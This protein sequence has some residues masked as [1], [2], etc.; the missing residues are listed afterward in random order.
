MD[1]FD[2]NRIMQSFRIIVDTRE[3]ET[4]RARQRYADMET[5]YSRAVLDYG[6]YTYNLTLPGGEL[7]DVSNRIKGRCV[8]ERKQ[9]LD[10][11]A[12]C[13]TRS[14]DRFKREFERA[15]AAGARVY[16]L[17]ENA[18]ID[19]ILSGQY[20]SRFRPQ[21][22]IASLMAWS[23]RNNMVT[24]FCDMKNS[25]RMIREILY[26]DAKERLERGEMWEEHAG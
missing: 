16:L 15:A 13:F 7:H 11:L 18:S 23:V 2:I 21:S 26:R 20:R 9:N 24:V 6:D 19:M 25:G 5:E 8:I 14:R 17:I 1:T 4:K 3:Q 10:E 12:M 22:F